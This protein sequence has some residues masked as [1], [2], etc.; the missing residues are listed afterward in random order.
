MCY[1]CAATAQGAPPAGA[2]DAPPIVPPEL[3]TQ[4][5]AIWPEGQPAD[6]DEMVPVVLTIGSDGSVEAVVVEP[7]V[8]PEFAAAAREAALRW[9]FEPARRGGVPVAA[10][11]RGEV[12]FVA[13]APPAAETAP[14]AAPDTSV[15][16]TPVAD[17][18]ALAA[19]TEAAAA[20]TAER[21]MSPPEPAEHARPEPAPSS[22]TEVKVVGRSRPPTR[23]ASDFRLPVGKQA[24]VP[25][26]NATQLLELAPGFFMTNE[27]G[28]GHAE[29]LFLRGFDAREGQDMELTVGGVP[30][31]ESGN[32]HGNGF[33]DLHFIIPE[34]VSSLRV[35][36]GP[37]DPHQ[38]NYAVAGSADF[39]LGL[40]QRGLTAKYSAGSFGT[41]RL[42]LAWGPPGESEHTFGGAEIYSTDGFG[43]NRDARRGAAMAQYEGELASGTW[44]LA[45]A[46]YA[47]EYHSAGVL[48]EED[49]AAGRKGFYDTY[50][51]RQGGSGSRFH[52]SADVETRSGDFKLYQQL[53]AIRRGMRVRG[54]F[55][56]FL[57]DTQEAEQTPHGQRGDLFDLD[58]EESTVGGRGAARTSAD[59]LGRPQELELGYFARFDDVKA[60]RQRVEATTGVPYLTETDLR[61]KLADLGL[62]VD[63]RLRPLESLTLLGGVRGD[64]F[65]YDVLDACAV[66]SVSQPDPN[67][68]PGDTSC[69]DQQR[70]GR[71]REPSQRSSTASTQ[72][73]P[74]ASVLVGPFS[75]VTFSLSY[76]KGVR[77]I[78]PNYITQDVAT[79]FASIDAGEGGVTYSRH[80]GHAAIVGRSVFFATHV[81]KDQIFSETEGRTILGGGTTRTGWSGA[82]RLV[83]TAFDQNLGVT[84][85]RSRFD[86]SGLLVPYVPDVV[87]RSD[88]VL[89][90][91]LPLRVADHP[92]SG[93]LGLGA[94]F[95]GRRA[96]PYGQ[97]SHTIFTLDGSATVGYRNVELGIEAKNLLDR[98]YRLGEY[99]YVSDFGSEEQPTLVPARHFT[100]G[101]PR[102]VLL[103]L[104]VNLGGG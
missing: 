41:E 79:P 57:L 8:A 49:V 84:L 77:S 67:N 101:E 62:Y 47:T 48:R 70:F 55:T 78:D 51:T 58:M 42:L 61:S 83:S 27:G 44:R 35:M 73:M 65:A 21:R 19:P 20:A 25:R 100:A 63:T 64:L 56:G 53:F 6:H 31:N 10:R 88:T 16:A 37:F 71:H 40:A 81:D 103:S 1:A 89:D 85:V 60:S 39:E 82:F 102:I 68:P 3:V 4:P 2:R 33:A 14:L 80:V 32:L 26:K 5:E 69:L 72:L 93:A 96:L 90:R 45:G 12:R 74:R 7:G 18:A 29:R 75:N 24:R 104:S 52:V 92:L 38:G 54:N 22:S 34:L 98:Q 66:Q 30:I 23:S 15:G 76:G 86:D 43:Q 95:V 59:V 17:S 91:E 87:V 97:R 28:E 50:D 11:V 36:E 99:N 46:A 94:A 9:T 13:A